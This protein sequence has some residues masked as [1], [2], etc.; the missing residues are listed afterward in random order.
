MV[1]VRYGEVTIKR[2]R[3]ETSLPPTL[4]L[5]V[6][7]VRELDPPRIR[8]VCAWCLLS[9]YSEPPEEAMSGRLVPAALDHERRCR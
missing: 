7:D 1:A 2:P 3:R 4:T 5:H 9:P 8:S 6:V